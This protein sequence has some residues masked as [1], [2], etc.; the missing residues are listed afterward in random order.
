MLRG[1][2]PP[3]PFP[4]K[5]ARSHQFF[6]APPFLAIITSSYFASMSCVSRNASWGYSVPEQARDQVFIR[7]Y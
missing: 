7:H 4:V 3:A 2:A 6:S 5:Y 1:S